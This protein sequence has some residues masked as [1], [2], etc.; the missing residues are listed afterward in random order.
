M[1]GKIA[2]V[3]SGEYL[4]VMHDL[5]SWLLHDRPRTYI[6][7]ATAAAPEGER[8]LAKWHALGRAAAERLDAQ[9]I[10]LDIRT[11][12]DAHDPKNVDALKNAGLIYLSGGSPSYL[13]KTLRNSPVWRAIFSQWQ[14]GASIAGC[15]AGAMALCGYVPDFLHPKAGGESG[16]GLITD[17]RVIPHF[18]RYSKFIPDFA[19]KPLLTHAHTVIGIDENTALVSTGEISDESANEW[20][21]RSMGVGSS[22]RIDSDRKYRINSPISL[23]VS[24]G[25]G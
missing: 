23:K 1:S 18:D 11:P 4:P 3:G 24:N 25:V 2:L 5:E 10:V 20:K 13:A 7:I 8:S 22:W 14:S 19:L 6:Q 17:A 21:F 16:L 9:Q 12:T 15:S